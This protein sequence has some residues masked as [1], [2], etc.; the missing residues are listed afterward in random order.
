MGSRLRLKKDKEDVFPSSFAGWFDATMQ[1]KCKPNK[2]FVTSRG[3]T[4][5]VS[6]NPSYHRKKLVKDTT[7]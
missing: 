6:K 2:S 4:K 3:R 7:Q 1:D 5:S